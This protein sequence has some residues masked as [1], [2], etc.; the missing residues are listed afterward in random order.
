MYSISYRHYLCLLT[1]SIF[2]FSA[3]VCSST[4]T[5]SS[6]QIQILEQSRQ[7]FPAQ[8]RKALEKKVIAAMKS[9][10]G[11]LDIHTLSNAHSKKRAYDY[12][13]SDTKVVEVDLAGTK[14]IVKQSDHTS[15]RR[16]RKS[17]KGDKSNLSRIWYAHQLRKAA[18]NYPLCRIHV[19]QKYAFHIPTKPEEWSD[20]NYLIVAEYVEIKRPSSLFL[21]YKIVSV[22]PF[23]YDN[24][25]CDIKPGSNVVV[26]RY[27]N[28][29][30]I[31]TEQLNYNMKLK[32]PF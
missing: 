32:M 30:I 14:Y 19:P 10:N 27:N 11:L 12:E 23:L 13:K 5:L 16:S 8:A 4:Y 17:H 3:V 29:A 18:L 2:S 31:D 21:W 15:D 20:D 22:F 26:D 25:Y 28:V 7:D 6:S 1:L 9:N 24:N